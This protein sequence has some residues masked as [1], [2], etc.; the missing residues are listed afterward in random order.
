MPDIEAA[1]PLIALHDGTIF[2][3]NGVHVRSLDRYG[4]LLADLLLPSDLLGGLDTMVVDNSGIYVSLRLGQIVKFGFDG[5]ELW[6]H[7]IAADSV[8]Q[9]G[10]LGVD[11]EGVYFGARS[12]EHNLDVRGFDKQ[13][14][15]L[16]R[17]EAVD[18][19]VAGLATWDGK[20]YAAGLSSRRYRSSG[21]LLLALGPVKQFRRIETYHFINEEGVLDDNRSQ[22][23]GKHQAKFI[24][25][26]VIANPD[27][28]PLRRLQF[29]VRKLGHY[30]HEH[31]VLSGDEWAHRNS[32]IPVP[33]IGAYADGVLSAGESVEVP[34]AVCQRQDYRFKMT[35]D[36][37]GTTAVK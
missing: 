1:I 20:V 36:L 10:V 14:N 11:A 25:P 3:A 19:D 35:L 34:V 9:G 23:S 27:G 26:V 5:T 2:V 28:R 15:V 32:R 18:G 13:G 31:A 37:Y 6:R 12:N 22:C 24:F 30:P 4:N 33:L 17:R 8:S 7:Q 21:G 29:L 16:W